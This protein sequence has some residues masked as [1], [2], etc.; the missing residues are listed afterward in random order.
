[1]L[2]RLFDDDDANFFDTFSF[3]EG[4]NAD[5]TIDQYPGQ[6]PNPNGP[7]ANQTKP[8]GSQPLHD[9]SKTVGNVEGA[10]NPYTSS[11]TVGTHTSR[12][13]MS[14]ST[15][16]PPRSA[17]E[18]GTSMATLKVNAGANTDPR[19]R[20]NAETSTDFT[21]KA[22]FGTNT[23]PPKPPKSTMG[24]NTISTH[25]K[26]DTGVGTDRVPVHTKPRHSRAGA[27]PP[28]KNR[29]LLKEQESFYRW[30]MNGR[31]DDMSRCKNILFDD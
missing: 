4:Q 3:H 11:T 23:D 10:R 28:L 6:R 1:M 9:P 26:S 22:T 14:T 2:A 31:M 20:S 15:S 18:M 19:L 30:V 5:G 17:R 13:A 8:N 7:N 21:R 27:L 24:I 29:D 12:H 16:P 25:G